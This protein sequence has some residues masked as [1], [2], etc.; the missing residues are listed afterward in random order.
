MVEP[1]EDAP[2]TTRRSVRGASLSVGSSLLGALI[3]GGLLIW[4]TRSGRLAEIAGY[5]VGTVAASLISVVLT[6]GTSFAYLT[7]SDD[8]RERIRRWRVAV[9]LPALLIASMG[10]TALYS[11]LDYSAVN[12][13]AA[14]L[15]VALNG[16]AELQYADLHRELRYG[17]SAAAATASKAVGAGLALWLLPLGP[18]LLVGAVVQFLVLQGFLRADRLRPPRPLFVRGRTVPPKECAPL[19][20]YSIAEY[21][22]SRLDTLALSVVAAPATV[23]AYAA[24]Y[25]IYQFVTSL[26]YT[27]ISSLVP[28]R[29][30]F[31]SS[32]DE[33]KSLRRVEGVLLA[34]SVLGVGVGLATAEIVVAVTGLGDGEA[35]TW[36]RLLLLATPFFLYNRIVAS[37]HI[38]KRDYRAAVRVP[39]SI[40]ACSVPLLLLLIPLLGATGAA[41]ATLGQEAAGALVMTVLVRRSTPSDAAGG[42]PQS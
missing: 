24:I 17:R 34:L 5:T 37:R 26:T 32:R 38:A 21:S 28:M 22:G 23:G 10:V 36:L 12:V 33:E 20:A 30:R 41:A 27:A 39:L 8:L 2:S 7:G 15:A 11:A 9:V 19:A 3:N 42:R 40:L 1:A 35:V 25:G 18:A 14:V 31:V 29:N 13:S 4:L 6:A 16:V